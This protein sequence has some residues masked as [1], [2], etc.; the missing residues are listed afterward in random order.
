[1]SISIDVAGG[2]QQECSATGGSSI[3]MTANTTLSEGDSIQSIDWSIDG[4]IVSSGGMITEFISL[5]NHV[6][7]ATV[8]TVNGLTASTA[9]NLSVN[10]T[11][12]PVVS[13]EFINRIT[14][15]PA[16]ELRRF[17]LLEIQAEATDICDPAPAVE[18]MFGAAVN[19]G[20]NVFI[21][22]YFGNVSIGVAAIDLTVRAT[23][24]SNNTSSA[25]TTLNIQ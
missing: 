11:T 1:M 18:A 21:M 13:S 9:V 12:P 10:D 7:N 17:N 23:D 16:V 25:T 15:M 14:N 22:K 24:S 20:D 2:L 4:I 8:T 5:G 3:S 6:I 19:D